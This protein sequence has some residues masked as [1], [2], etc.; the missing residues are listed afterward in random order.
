MSRPLVPKMAMHWI[1]RAEVLSLIAAAGGTVLNVQE[2]QTPGY[3][4]CQY[5]VTTAGVDVP[6]KSS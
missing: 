2:E 1:A 4:S 5:W 6:E 3:L